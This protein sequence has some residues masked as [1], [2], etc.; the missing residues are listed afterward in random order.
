MSFLKE[1]CSATQA[2]AA[3]HFNV[4]PQVIHL[5]LKRANITWTPE[6]K[7]CLFTGCYGTVVAKGYCQG[8]YAQLKAG[9]TIQNIS[10][11]APRGGGLDFIKSHIGTM[12]QDCIYWP[13]TVSDGYGQ[14]AYNGKRI[15]AHRATL[16]LNVGP[17]PEGK[18]F[19]CH[20]PYKCSSTACVNPNHLR[21][22]TQQENGKDEARKRKLTRKGTILTR[23]QVVEIR[24]KYQS[25]FQIAEEYN[26]QYWVIKN[27]IE[28]KTWTHF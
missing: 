19:A 23:E 13:F 21:W 4:S 24:A 28:R 5:T 1:N 3:R 7:K 10:K 26:V 27:C 11:R 17:P 16:F 6:P 14:V 22:D 20:D 8:H 12:A 15:G 18:N 9:K 2:D 25:Y